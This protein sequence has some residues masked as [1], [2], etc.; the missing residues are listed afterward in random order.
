MPELDSWHL[1]QDL[2]SQIPT[3]SHLPN[4]DNVAL[5][6]FQVQHLKDFPVVVEGL[7]V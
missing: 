5:C 7:P 4:C 2:A 1:E 3:A 6:F